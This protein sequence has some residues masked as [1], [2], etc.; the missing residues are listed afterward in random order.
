MSKSAMRLGSMIVI[1]LYAALGVAALLA[2]MFLYSLLLV[3]ILCFAILA[4]GYNVLVGYTRCISFGHSAFVATSAYATGY[5]LTHNLPTE[6]GLF[7]G[8]LAS[9]LLGYVMG[10]LAIRRE[11]LY[12]GMITLAQSQ[13]LYFLYSMAPFTGGEMGLQGVPRGKLLGFIDLSNDLVLYYFVL[14]MFVA[15]F[16]FIRRCIYSP[17]GH[18]LVAIRENE[19]RAISLGYDV[20]RFKLLTF[21]LSATISGFA[22]SL[23]TLSFGLATLSD[24][25]WSNAA[26]VLVMTLVGGIG[27]LWGP[28]VGAAIV[29]FLQH[30]LAERFA[31]LLTALMGL[32][33]VV[34]VL[35]FRRGI[36]GE[37]S[38]LLKKLRTRLFRR[39]QGNEDAV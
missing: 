2:P 22:G 6:V 29:V 33:F 7:A 39:D 38:E 13:L 28:V 10:A 18:V 8:I 26:D 20:N 4:C 21:V 15:C 14:A 32:A 9:V 23:K 34:C 31:D 35:V 5:L 12:F 1:V 16:L 24:A 19:S 36:V 11:G 17:F 3:N 27:T 30:Y 25:S 37:V